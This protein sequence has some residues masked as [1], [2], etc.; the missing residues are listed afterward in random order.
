MVFYVIVL[1]FLMTLFMIKFT[2]IVIPTYFLF[3]EMPII[4]TKFAI[5]CILTYEQVE[6]TTSYRC[7]G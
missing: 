4:E 3:I 7:T 6:P 2:S 5:I 1:T